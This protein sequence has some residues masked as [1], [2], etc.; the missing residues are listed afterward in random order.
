M[1]W[2]TRALRLGCLVQDAA[3]SEQEAGIPFCTSRCSRMTYDQ[4][5]RAAQWSWNVS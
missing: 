4:D 5:D 1:D 3:V 2:G